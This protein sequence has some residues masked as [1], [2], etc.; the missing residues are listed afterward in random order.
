MM[1]AD[2]D[3]L[4]VVLAEG[5]RVGA[6]NI[7]PQER[8]AFSVDVVRLRRQ[9]EIADSSVDCV[10]VTV[11][12]RATVAPGRGDQTPRH[13]RAPG[14]SFRRSTG[15]QGRRN[16]PALGGRPFVRRLRLL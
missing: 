8:F 16:A 5:A 7:A 4:M 2:L 6:V 12:Q 9:R 15:A 11:V 1:L 14:R 13:G 10:P 3:R